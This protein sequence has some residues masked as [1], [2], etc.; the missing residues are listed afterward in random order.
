MGSNSQA[1]VLMVEDFFDVPNT[2]QLVMCINGLPIF[3]H[4]SSFSLTHTEKRLAGPQNFTESIGATS[5]F[6][7]GTLI[8]V[9]NIRN[10]K[11]GYD[12][13]IFQWHMSFPQLTRWPQIG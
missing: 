7:G 6:R 10:Q 3:L 13:L 8:Y 9:V 4:C 5:I 1:V 2:I 11:E 12:Y